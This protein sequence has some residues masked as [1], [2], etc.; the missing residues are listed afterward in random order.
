MYKYVYI[1]DKTGLFKGRCLQRL[2]DSLTV[3]REG[4]NMTRQRRLNPAVC[5]ISTTTGGIQKCRFKWWFNGDLM[6][7]DGFQWDLMVI[8]SGNLT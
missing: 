4:S 8:P 3:L 6:S 7:F 2:T 1:L 5:P